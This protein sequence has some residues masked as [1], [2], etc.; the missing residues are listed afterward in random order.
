MTIDSGELIVETPAAPPAPATLLETP[1]TP[2][3]KAAEPA[4]KGLSVREGVEAALKT[5][6]DRPR[7]EIGRFAQK[8]ADD[9]ALKAA[10]VP[11]TFP[12]T[13]VAA[14]KPERPADMPKAWGADKSQLWAAMTPEQRAYVTD[15]ESQ[16]EGFH[17]KFGGLA[18][19]HEA[20]AANNT[21][22]PE[23]LDRVNRVETAMIQD[24]SQGLTMA[25]E[26]VGMDRNATAKA[27]MGALQKLG[28]QLPAHSDQT[29]QQPEQ[30]QVPPEVAA[31]RQEL[32][33]IKGYFAQQQAEVQ[34]RE[35]EKA[36]GVV[37]AFFADASNKYAND[38]ANEISAELKA[39]KAMGKPLDLKSA[40]ER[41]LWTR[42]DLREKLIA[43]Q[44][45]PKQA[46]AEKA[47]AQALEKARSASR[48]V[49]GSPPLAEGRS[50]AER[51]SKLRDEIA[52]RVRNA[53]GRV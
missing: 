8:Q 48:S 7:D 39:M 30:P 13:P 32:D 46:E 28:V 17:S 23:V 51:P 36:Q 22:L 24:P 5:I 47:Q 26:M 6:R 19:W 44:V 29:W 42:P 45:A 4:I 12:A 38:V 52:M 3:P 16:M 15:R 37:Q 40:Y 18:P 43:E 27:L 11:Q 1:V 10:T 34:K 50:S 20:A 9:A 49:A 2:E 31:L 25:C 14:V 21:T 41:A 35:L 53:A 33:G